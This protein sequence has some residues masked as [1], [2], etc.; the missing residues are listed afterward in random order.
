MPDND[1]DWSPPP[2]LCDEHGV[3]GRCGE[4]ARAAT[5]GVAQMVGQPCPACS[6]LY[7]GPP[8]PHRVAGLTL[9]DLLADFGLLDE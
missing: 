6:L 4:R 5:A 9:D 7:G 2:A 8:S 1:A 3:C